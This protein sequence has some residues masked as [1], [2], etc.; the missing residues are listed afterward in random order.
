M[1]MTLRVTSLALISLVIFL[2]GGVSAIGVSRLFKDA[3]ERSY[4]APYLNW[5]QENGIIKGFDDGTFRPNSAVSRAELITILGRYHQIMH[6]GSI[7]NINAN[8][9]NENRNRNMNRH[10][11]DNANRNGSVKNENKNRNGHEDMD[12]EENEN[13]NSHHEEDED[14]EEHTENHN[15]NHHS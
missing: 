13:T 5:A 12:E 8:V 11:Q 1:K 15:T 10:E 3:D 14:D 9:G 7:E 4:Y 2:A 6:G